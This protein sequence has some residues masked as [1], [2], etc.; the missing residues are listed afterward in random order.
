MAV[1]ISAVLALTAIIPQRFRQIPERIETSVMR[2]LRE[3]K[4]RIER[5]SFLVSM[6]YIPGMPNFS[7]TSDK[8]AVLLKLEG[9]IFISNGPGDPTDVPETTQTIKKLIGKYPIFGICLGHQIISLAYGAKTYKLKFGHRGGSSRI[10]K[11]RRLTNY[12]R[13]GTDNKH[14]FYICSRGCRQPKWYGFD[15]YSYQSA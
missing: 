4:S 13:T 7:I 3:P 12:D 8:V 9:G 5:F 14:F 6:P 10:V 1:R 15:R 11:F 2:T